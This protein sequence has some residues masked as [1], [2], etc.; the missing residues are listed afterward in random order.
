MRDAVLYRDPTPDAVAEPCD[1]ALESHLL[2]AALDASGR[3]AVLARGRRRIW[4]AGTVLPDEAPMVRFVLSGAIGSFAAVDFL[5]LSY[6]GPGS[7]VGLEAAVGG[8]AP[9]VLQA[10]MTAETFELPA[11]ALV[12]AI[13]QAGAERL[14]GLSAARRLPEAE[15]ELTCRAT[16]GVGPRLARWLLRLHG[17]VQGGAI[18]MSQ[19][20]LSQLLG[21]QRTSV[22]AAA[23]PLQERQIVRYRRGQIRVLEVER[24][25]AHAC[26]CARRAPVRTVRSWA[27]DWERT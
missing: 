17:L 21:V 25:A 9:A 19:E 13:G 18:A 23:H 4:S 6:F 3:A 22:N 2:F 10:I 1:P 11:A 26:P 14:L 24:L 8:E 12:G 15:I 20:R 5:C 7:V 16:H 27:G